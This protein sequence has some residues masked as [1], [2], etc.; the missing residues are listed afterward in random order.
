MRKYK[1]VRNLIPRTYSVIFSQRGKEVQLSLLVQ[2]SPWMR[3]WLAHYV[4]NDVMASHCITLGRDA[5]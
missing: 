3:P 2:W 1:L 5:Y 4:T